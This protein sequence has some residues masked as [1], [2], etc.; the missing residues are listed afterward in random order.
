MEGHQIELRDEPRRVEVLVDD[1]VIA[2]SDRVVTLHETGLP[3]RHYFPVEDVSMDRLHATPTETVCPFKGQ[4]S[5]W[6]IGNGDDERRDIAW[7]YQDPIDG[8]ERIAGRICFYAERT[9]HVVDGVPLERPQS[10][11]STTA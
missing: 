11:W 2:A 1:V 3:V 5:Y 6:S 10:P 4:A 8:M 7:S 9:D